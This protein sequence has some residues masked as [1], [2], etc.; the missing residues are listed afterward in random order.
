[1]LLAVGV[2]WR[3]GQPRVPVRG[4]DRTRDD[5]RLDERHLMPTIGRALRLTSYLGE[6]DLCLPHLDELIGKGLVTLDE[7]EVVRYVGRQRQ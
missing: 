3:T 1:M 6:D 4:H 2:G 7:V 5:P